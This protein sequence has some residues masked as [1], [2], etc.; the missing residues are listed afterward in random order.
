MRFGLIVA[1]VT[2]ALISTLAATAESATFVVESILE[3]LDAPIVDCPHYWEVLAS[4]TERV[5][6]CAK[7]DGDFPFFKL[8]WKEEA[9]RF[10][11]LVPAGPWKQSQGG[12]VASIDRPF[13]GPDFAITVRATQ[14]FE[15]AA[16]HG[17]L[18]L[19]MMP[20]YEQGPRETYI[21][22]E[23]GVTEPVLLRK[24]Q[25]DY[26]SLAQITNVRGSVVLDVVVRADGTVGAVKVLKC[27]RPG[28][29]FEKAAR[30]A[31]RE[32]VFTPATLNGSPVS[33][34]IAVHVDFKLR[35]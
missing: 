26:P 2:A 6:L 1:V 12:L 28:M 8:Q 29:G 15:G 25:P 32:W 9:H 11:S 31:V 27:D 5:A 23:D 19:V 7:Y 33:A 24:R 13:N 35:R 3:G 16:F 17:L 21:A 22:G 14:A 10:P 18:V 4:E 20:E 30:D 34:S